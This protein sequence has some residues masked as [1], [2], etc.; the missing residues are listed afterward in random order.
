MNINEKPNDE[1]LSEWEYIPDNGI[2]NRELQKVYVE[3][4][5]HDGMALEQVP[6]ENRYPQVC[7]AAVKDNGLA[8]YYVPEGVRTPG[9]CLIAIQQ[10]GMALGSVPRVHQTPEL[11]LVAVKQ[12]GMALESVPLELRTAELCLEAM[13]EYG[14]V[15]QFVPE[16]LITVE[17]CWLAFNSGLT[18][19]PA[20]SFIPKVFQVKKFEDLSQVSKRVS[21][22]EYEEA[23]FAQYSVDRSYLKRFPLLLAH[24]EAWF[25]EMELVRLNGRH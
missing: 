23:L 17:M 11:C 20:R 8:L 14:G 10:N 25:H 16:G 21:K 18:G 12:S 24:Q 4:V 1:E 19:F 2:Y 6:K 13:K 9:I 5:K 22:E 7:S 3:S 15:L